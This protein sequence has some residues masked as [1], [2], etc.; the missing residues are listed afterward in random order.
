MLTAR[1]MV[2]LGKLDLMEIYSNL[3][4]RIIR[5]KDLVCNIPLMEVSASVLIKKEPN[6]FTMDG[7]GMV[8]KKEMVNKPY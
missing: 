5:K 3:P 2:L 4:T 8:K 1:C 7:M 6:N